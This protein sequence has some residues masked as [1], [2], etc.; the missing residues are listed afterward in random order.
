MGAQAL[1]QFTFPEGMLKASFIRD[2]NKARLG[3]VYAMTSGSETHFMKSDT[4]LAR[5]THA[6]GCCV[7]DLCPWSYACRTICV[8]LG[9][10]TTLCSVNA[11]SAV[12]FVC[13]D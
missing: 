12:L 2:L 3:T 10:Y 6:F 1:L 13:V 7:A 9:T 8:T 4:L 11:V 5:R